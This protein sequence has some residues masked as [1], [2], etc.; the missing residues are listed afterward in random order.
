MPT[1]LHEGIGVRV[2]GHIAN[3][4]G[5]FDVSFVDDPQRGFYEEFSLDAPSD[6][7]ALGAARA[8]VG[9]AL[10]SVGLGDQE[11]LWSEIERIEEPSG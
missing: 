1:R 9:A 6:A 5:S 11:L 7:E 10:K 4:T 8:A 3:I 2:G